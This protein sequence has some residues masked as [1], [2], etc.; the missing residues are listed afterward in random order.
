M[1]ADVERLGRLILLID[2]CEIGEITNLMAKKF[3]LLMWLYVYFYI[4]V[5]LNIFHT[6]AYV[7]YVEYEGKP[8]DC[9]N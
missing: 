1:E 9:L 6:L 4:L 5:Y 2:S 3:I 8:I 7:R